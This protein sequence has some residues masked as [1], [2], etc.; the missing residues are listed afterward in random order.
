MLNHLQGLPD[1]TYRPTIATGS[2]HSSIETN[3]SNEIKCVRSEAQTND[4][5]VMM[6]SNTQLP[7]VALKQIFLP[8][9]SLAF[10]TD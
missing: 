1:R 2:N 7:V 3:K 10:F 5:S 9:P 8:L 6:T 4:Q